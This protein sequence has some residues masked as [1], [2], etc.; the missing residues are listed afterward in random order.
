MIAATVFVVALSLVDLATDG[1][2][3]HT[4]QHT[5]AILSRTGI[6]AVD[7]ITYSGF[8]NTHM[9]LA[10]QNRALQH[11][12]ETYQVQSL[13]YNALREE[14]AQ[15][16]VMAH[17]AQDNTGITVPVVSSFRSSPYGTFLVGAG[18]AD[19]IIQNNLVLTE[20]RFV[21]GRITDVGNH[22]ALVSEILAP[23]KTID[24]IIAGSATTLTSTGGGTATARMSHGIN[25]A[26]GDIVTA[27]SAGARPIGIVGHVESDPVSAYSTVY[28]RIPQNIESLR[29]VFV[30]SDKK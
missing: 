16:A 2:V 17:L 1:I 18:S 6:R 7:T 10:A 26:I 9:N 8:F 13:A 12:I 15:L 28:V 24:A 22:T 27:P 11:Q 21:I 5:A 19:G 23:R 20:D 3:R 30:L 14:N 4:L 25:V 29:Y